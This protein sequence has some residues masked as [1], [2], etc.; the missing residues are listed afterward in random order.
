MTT[1]D[2]ANRISQLIQDHQADIGSEWIEQLEALTVRS[3]VVSKDQLRKHCQQFLAAFAQATRGG[4][5]QNIDH[6][7][8]DEVRDILS[9]ISST[10]ARNGSTP[11]ETATFVFSLKQPL[12]TRL[13]EGFAGDPA[14][15]ASAS[16]TISSLLDKMGL[17]TIEVFQRARDQIIVR[18]QQ[19]LL[20]L[21]TPVVKLWDGILALPLIGTLD[22]ARTQVVMENILQKIVDTGAAIAIIDITGVPTVDTLVAQHLMK[23]IAAARLMGADCI[24]SGI[25]PQIAQTIVHLGVNLED[26]V[27]KAT[28]ADAFLVALERTGTSVIKRTAHA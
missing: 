26:V 12:F 1:Q 5:L 3:S 27:T 22:S 15:L 21:S 11:S 16:W 6:R 2:Y 19:E 28:L 4:E 24:I 10:R 17:Y 23:T 20:E 25:R 18:Q 8:W 9:E 14:A 7:S 13:N